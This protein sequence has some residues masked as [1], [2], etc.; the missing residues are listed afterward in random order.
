MVGVN[1]CSSSSSQQLNLKVYAVLMN[2]V[3]LQGICNVNIVIW[4][5]IYC[6]FEENGVDCGASIFSC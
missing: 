6:T 3:L 4:L 2:H 1:Q 5:H